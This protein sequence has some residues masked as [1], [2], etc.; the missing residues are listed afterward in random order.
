LLHLLLLL[1]LLLPVTNCFARTLVD[2]P[3]WHWREDDWQISLNSDYVTTTAN[4]SD[5]GGAYQGLLNGGSFTAYEFRP[6][7][8]Y[9]WTHAL[10]MYFGV[11]G[12][13][14]IERSS[15]SN[16]SNSHLND[17]YLGFDAILWRRGVVVLAEGEAAATTNPISTTSNTVLT[18]DE[19]NFMRGDLYIYRPFHL[20]NPFAHGGFEYRDGGLSSL[21][22]YGLGI[23]RPFASQYL[24]GIGV[25][26]EGTAIADRGQVINRTEINDHNDASSH[27]FYAYNPVDVDFRAWLGWSPVAEWQIK[28][29]YAQSFNGT[30][31]AVTQTGFLKLQYDFDRHPDRGSFATYHDQANMLKARDNRTHAEKR[32]IPYINDKQLYQDEDGFIPDSNAILPNSATP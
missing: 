11:D 17:L 26:G 10:S 8:R 30:R 5:S 9:N 3:P 27:L 22:F 1:T 16:S 20:A 15:I 24:V 23:E 6:K 32:G 25:E 13:S 19:V 21:Y 29:G 18:S 12:A 7:F 14:A 31:A 4:Y 2:T 28:I